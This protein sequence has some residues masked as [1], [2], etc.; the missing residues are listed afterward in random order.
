MSELSLY[1][2]KI[3]AT[4]QEI[5]N[6]TNLIQILSKYGSVIVGG[7]FKYDLMWGPDIDICVICDD[8]RQS[9]ILAL[10]EVI[11]LRLSQKYEYG[12]FVSFPRDKRPKSYILNLILPFEDQKW[13][14]EVWFFEKYPEQQSEIDNLIAEKLTDETKQT[15]LE[16]KKQR[17]ESG[18]NKHQVSSTE[19]YKQILE[20]N[21]TDYD[22][23]V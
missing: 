14:I 16:M 2:Q 5:L 12:D 6:S 13:E 23:I 20:N 3:K 8:T 4:A 10:K 15:I 7:S 1:S 9:S 22:Q 17:D 21:I 18:N 19:I 11:D